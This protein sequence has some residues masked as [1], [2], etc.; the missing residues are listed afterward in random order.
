MADAKP[1]PVAGALVGAGVLAA[2]LLIARA[3]LKLYD[4]PVRRRL[5]ARLLRKE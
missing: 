1:A 3:G 4:E 2:A 5:A